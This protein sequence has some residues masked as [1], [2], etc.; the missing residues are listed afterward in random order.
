MP[1]KTHRSG[2]KVRT[3]RNGSTRRRGVA[4]LTPTDWEVL[5]E[6]TDADVVAAASTDKDNRPLSDDDLKRMKRRSRVFVMRRALRLSQEAF[7]ARFQIPLGTLRDWEQGRT[8]PDQAAIAYLKVIAADP[9]FVARALG[10]AV[11]R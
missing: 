3:A 5:A 1:A 2:P 7:A 10:S 6:M 9:A 11:E 8:E 4:P